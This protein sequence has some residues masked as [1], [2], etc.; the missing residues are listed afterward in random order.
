MENNVS[1]P[2]AIGIIGGSGLY[3]MDSLEIQEEREV[4]TP[5]GKPSAPLVIGEME[6]R[7]VAFLPRHGVHHQYNPSEVP[8]RANIWAL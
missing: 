3:E 8:Y 2:V 7:R 5:F 6:G 1:E 4:D